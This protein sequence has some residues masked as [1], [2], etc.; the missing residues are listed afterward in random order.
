MNEELMKITG[1]GKKERFVP[2]GNNM[3]KALPKYLF[4]NRPTPPP[5]GIDNVFLSTTSVPLME[6]S[7][8]LMF[9]RLTKRYALNKI[10]R[11]SLN[12]LVD[13]DRI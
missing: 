6:N 7:A 12:N 4:R 3:H 5:S 1:K 10:I 2:I 13:C 11:R 9:A 8:K